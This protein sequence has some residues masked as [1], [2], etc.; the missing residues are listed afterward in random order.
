VRFD[1]GLLIVNLAAATNISGWTIA[2]RLQNS[3]GGI[4]GLA[5]FSC[6]SGFNGVSGITV[7]DGVNGVFQVQVAGPQTS[8]L[9][10]KN[11]AM[12]ISRLDSGFHTQLVGGFL[13]LTPS[14]STT[15]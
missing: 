14:Y 10:F 8:G 6:A 7:T 3:F 9:D 2:M 1:D 5:Q 15:G 13:C 4:S 11:Y 12:D